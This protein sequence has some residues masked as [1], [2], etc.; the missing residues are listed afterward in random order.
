MTMAN[1]S[2]EICDLVFVENSVGRDGSI[3]KL[4]MMNMEF[5]VFKE[6]YDQDYWSK[7]ESYEVYGAPMYLSHDI[8]KVFNKKKECI[9]YVVLSEVEPLPQALYFFQKTVTRTEC[10]YK[11]FDLTQNETYTFQFN[12]KEYV[13]EIKG[14]KQE[15]QANEFIGEMQIDEPV[16][17]EKEEKSSGCFPSFNRFFKRNK[18]SGSSS[19]SSASSSSSSTELGIE[20]Y[21]SS[22]SSPNLS[23]F[24]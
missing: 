4:W 23:G 22:R 19:F 16:S 8:A 1:S 2:N 14:N 15:I 21:S 20:G 7:D 17:E 12:G 5:S 18:N 6:Q 11:Q 9:G 24:R 10:L 3:F 13:L